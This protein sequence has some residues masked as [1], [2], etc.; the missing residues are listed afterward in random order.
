M[1]IYTYTHT[2]EEEEE[3]LINHFVG[4]VVNYLDLSAGAY[5]LSSP[6]EE[7]YTQTQT[8]EGIN[9]KGN[10]LMCVCVGVWVCWCMHTL[11]VKALIIKHI[12]TH[13]HTHTHRPLLE[14]AQSFLPVL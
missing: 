11:F 9:W 4:S 7:T 8:R 6:K 5:M 1:L 3:P 2:Q 10:F 14:G 13:T 12:H